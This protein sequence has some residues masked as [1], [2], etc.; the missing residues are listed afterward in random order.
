MDVESSDLDGRLEN[1]KPSIPCKEV[2]ALLRKEDGINP[3]RI[4]SE[5]TC[6]C[7]EVTAW[8]RLVDP[9]EAT[10]DTDYEGTPRSKNHGVE[11]I[12]GVAVPKND[13]PAPVI[14]CARDESRTCGLIKRFRVEAASS[15]VDQ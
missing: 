10:R 14:R 8:P 1:R 6:G 7:L 12:T 5:K 13:K 2:A 15:I 4:C 9:A 11:Q 3:L